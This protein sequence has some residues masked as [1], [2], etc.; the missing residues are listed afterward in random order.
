MPKIH[1]FGLFNSYIIHE[2]VL[3]IYIYHCYY[4]IIVISFRLVF[5]LFSFIY[6]FPYL[7]RFG[8]IYYFCSVFF[9]LAAFNFLYS[10]YLY[11]LIIM[12]ICFI[13]A[14]IIGIIT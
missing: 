5:I 6:H 4:F 7:F 13:S 9:N 12:I 14:I 2:I 11:L 3:L 10:P 1:M 8:L